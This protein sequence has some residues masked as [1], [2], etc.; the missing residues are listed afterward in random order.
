M[1]TGTPE[2]GRTPKAGLQR[3]PHRVAGAG[4]GTPAPGEGYAL[5]IAQREC[6]KL[7]FSHPHDLEDVVVGVGLVAAKRASVISRGPTLNDVHVAM[8]LFHLRDESPVP[9]TLTRAFAGL[10]HS[11]VAQRRFVD[12]VSVAQLVAESSDSTS[13]G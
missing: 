3:S 11:Y 10:A 12:A 13:L 1:V 5:T 4:Q 7:V 9:R 2:V 8:D 6:E